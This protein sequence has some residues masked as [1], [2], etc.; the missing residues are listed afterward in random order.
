MKN[1]KLIINF[2]EGCQTTALKQ[3][4]TTW[5][6]LRTALS[7]VARTGSMGAAEYHGA[8]DERRKAD[9]DGMGWIPCSVIDQIGRRSQSNMDKA[10]LLVLDIDTGMMLDDVKSRIAGL[11]AAIHSSY[12]H[13]PEKP[14]WRVVMPLNEPIPANE[15][16][17]VFD[18]FQEKF[19]GLLDASCGHDPA[20]LYY[21]PSCPKDAAHLFVYEHLEGELLDGAVLACKPA[22]TP[23]KSVP[24][25]APAKPGADLSLAAGV[26]EGSR[27]NEAFKR[28][29]VLFEEGVSHE[30]VNSALEAWNV[31]NTPPLDERELQQTIKSARKNVNKKVM[32]AAEAIDKIVDELNELYAWVKKTGRIYRFEE[33]DFVSI[34]H[35][36]QQYANATLRVQ[37]GDSVKWLTH[38]DVWQKSPKRRTHA[39]IDFVPGAGLIVGNNINLWQGWGVEPVAGDIK[40]WDD[41]LDHLFSGHPDMRHW[42]EQWAAYPIQHPGEK[43]TT[44]VVMWSAKQGVGKS[45]IGDTIGKL[46]GTHFRT[47]SAAELHSQFNGWMKGC[48]F[49][50]GEENSSSDQRAD[51]NKLKHLITGTTIFVN[52]KFQPALELTNCVNFLFTSNHP[53]AFHLDDADRRFFVWE[54]T[55][56]RKPNEF[57]DDFIDW[58]DKRGGLAA[59]M[60]H[61]QRIDLTGFQP[62]GN[63]PMTEAKE[64]MIRQSKS[65]VER[66]LS[67][68]LEDGASVISVFGKEIS[69]LDEITET[70]NRQRRSRTTTTAV[71]RALRRHHRCASR[72]VVTGSGRKQLC[73]LV[74]HDRWDS[75][76]NPAWAAEFERAGL[77]GLSL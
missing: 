25:K 59:L 71:S 74:N 10:Y 19:D 15:I 49:A 14:K 22:A 6:E 40:P 50:L 5:E 56:G 32:A 52:E 12:S 21:L 34:E 28:A 45:M 1:V 16:Q 31:L 65:D 75:V 42:F 57:Y 55:G 24:V 36:R 3:F 29:C 66:W 33:R 48:Q 37:V 27:N 20:R 54:I 61:L 11:E 69:C 58:R 72:R 17:K 4:E 53:D 9:K 68:A 23:A 2:V 7:S 60:E 62:K 44:A 77:A 46:Y 8:S 41:M 38:A 35:L 30:E 64:E 63:A 43:L 47:I 51:A 26:S 70:Y 67:D 73:S 13:T 39:N 18:H 76:D